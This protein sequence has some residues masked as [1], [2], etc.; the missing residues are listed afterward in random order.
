MATRYPLVIDTSDDNKIKEL[1]SG[2]NLNLSNNNI[3][4]VNNISSLGTITAESIA[5]NSTTFTVNGTNLAAVAISGSYD[6]L[7]DKP[8]LFSGAY[9]SLTGAPSIPSKTFELDD[10]AG[11]YPSEGQVL[12]W[13]NTNERYE[14][15]NFS[16]AG[17]VESIDDVGFLNLQGNQVLKWNGNVWTNSYVSWDHIVDREEVVEQGG[18]L[19]GDLIGSVFGTDSSIL[20]DADTGN[21]QAT[22]INNGPTNVTLGNLAQSSYLEIKNTSDEINFRGNINFIGC[23]VSGLNASV[24]DLN[25]NGNTIHSQDSSAIIFV[26]TVEFLSDL[27]VYNNITA[28]NN[29]IATKL[30]ATTATINDLHI[31]GTL[32]GVTV[33]GGSSIGNLEIIGNTIN[34][35]DSSAI[36]FTPAV[37]FSSDVTIENDLV[38]NNDLIVVGNIISQNSGTPEIFSD[39]EILLTATTS[40]QITSS[41]LQLASFT[42]TERNTLLPTNGEVIYNTTDNKFQGYAN[43]VWVDLH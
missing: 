4:N 42:T 12:V 25:I 14:P 1:P 6:D 19:R 18:V 32:T 20:F 28:D 15:K 13:N 2:D 10:V 35:N 43:G 9:A 8:T 39:N 5:L 22:S 21:L 34:S 23:T 37:T 40:V 38:V 33:G 36:I 30:T 29:L 26:P 41:T 11:T 24:G 17:T 16:G 27:N 31:T 3:V 7:T